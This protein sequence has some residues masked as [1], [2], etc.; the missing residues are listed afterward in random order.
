MAQPT[1]GALHA[2]LRTESATCNRIDRGLT[3]AA[4][5]AS[6]SNKMQ[7]PLFAQHPFRAA[8]T[9]AGW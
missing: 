9:L 1:A 7:H 6:I 4:H 2:S 5:R 8:L 3:A